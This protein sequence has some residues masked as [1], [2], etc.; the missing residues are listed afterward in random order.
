MNSSN[1]TSQLLPIVF[2]G[3]P[4][5][6]NFAAARHKTT[7]IINGV[8]FPHFKKNFLKEIEEDGGFYSIGFDSTSMDKTRYYAIVIRLLLSLIVKT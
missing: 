3:S 6:E 7:A 2:A 5:A 4:A 1:C 8:L